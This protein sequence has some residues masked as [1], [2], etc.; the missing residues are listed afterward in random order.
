VLVARGRDRE[1]RALLQSDTLFRAAYRG[2]LF[3]LDAMAGADFVVD[4]EAYAA[5]EL[6][7]FRQEPSSA[8][9]LDLWF[10]AAWEA[11]RGQAALAAE[12][13]DSLAARTATGRSRRDS[14][15][16][17]SLAARVALA[18]GDSAGALRRLN[19]LVPTTDMDDLAW[20]PWE[21][22]GGERMLLARL[23]LARGEAR[24]ALDAASAFDA[25]ATVMY[26]PYLPASLALRAD[27][28]AR[29]GDDKLAQRLRRRL[30]LLAD[31]GH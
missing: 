8:S 1:A 21:S 28:A 25:P 14:L 29:L 15:L 6:A 27:A 23:L 11:Y 3:L 22:L 10:L 13:A 5:G 16:V 18:R 20:K 9:V 17:G 4:A 19:A 24:A 26:L 31:T 2:Q 30:E 12:L 7:R